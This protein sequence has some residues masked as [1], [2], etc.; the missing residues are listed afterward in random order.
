[1]QITKSVLKS[2]QSSINIIKLISNIY[3]LCALLSTVLYCVMGRAQSTAV[4]DGKSTEHSSDKI[5][6]ACIWKARVPVVS[7]ATLPPP[8]PIVTYGNSLLH[9]CLGVHIDMTHTLGVPQYGDLSLDLLQYVLNQRAAP[10]R[11][12]QVYLLLEGQHLT[13][14]LPAV[15]LMMS[16]WEGQDVIPIPQEM[17]QTHQ[18][19]KLNSLPTN[20]NILHIHNTQH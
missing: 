12:D 8:S 6:E 18:N 7:T 14:T 20:V 15:H 16:W 10:S 2:R 4:C 3:V 17:L 9:I 13:H 1:M 5:E 11:D 19:I